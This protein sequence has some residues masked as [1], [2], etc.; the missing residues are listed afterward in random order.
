MCTDPD[1]HLSNTCCNLLEILIRNP[2]NVENISP[3][4]IMIITAYIPPRRFVMTP[5]G[6]MKNARGGGRIVIE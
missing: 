1:Y 3:R 6:D 2:I 4:L 5:A